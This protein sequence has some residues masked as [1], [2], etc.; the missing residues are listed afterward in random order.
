M[1]GSLAF[2]HRRLGRSQAIENFARDML[3]KPFDSSI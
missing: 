2:S 1:A 3:E